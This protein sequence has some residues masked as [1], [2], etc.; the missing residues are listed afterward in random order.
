MVAGGRTRNP[1]LFRVLYDSDISRLELLWH[2]V[3]DH[4]ARSVQLEDIYYCSSSSLKMKYDR[5]RVFR[6]AEEMMDW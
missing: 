6:E 1:Q 5:D 2:V 4:S 3:I